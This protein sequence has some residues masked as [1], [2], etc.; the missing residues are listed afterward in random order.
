M[1]S[2]MMRNGW[3]SAVRL[4]LT[5]AMGLSGHI[6]GIAK[7]WLAKVHN[8]TL[9]QWA[10]C[11]VYVCALAPSWAA[12]EGETDTLT[13]SPQI[14]PMVMPVT[15][16]VVSEEDENEVGSGKI[17]AL[18]GPT[19]NPY[20]SARS[21]SVPLGVIYSANPDLREL[22]PEDFVSFQTP[23]GDQHT[24]RVTRA[25]ATRFGN[26]EIT[27]ENDGASLFIVA[28][29]TGDFIADVETGSQT[30]RAFISDGQTVVYSTDNPELGK[31]TIV[32]D[33][34]FHDLDD[35]NRQFTFEAQVA[36]PPPSSSSSNTVIALG[37]LV[38]NALAADQSVVADIEYYVANLNSAYQDA[39]ASIRF[40][41]SQIATY[42]PGQ[43]VSAGSLGPILNHITCGTIDCAPTSGVNKLVDDW[44]TANKLDMV[45]QLLKYAAVTQPDEE[46]NYSINWGIAQLPFS[47][48]DLT[49]PAILK[50]YTYSVNGLYNPRINIKAGAYLLAHEIGHNFGLWH[51]RETLVSQIPDYDSWAEL[52]PLLE[53]VMRYPYGIGYRFGESSGTTMSY[54][55]NNVNLLSTPN[56]TSNGGI[57]IGRPIGDSNQSFSAQAVENIMA[58]YKA[59]FSNTPPAPTNIEVNG[60][61]GKIVVSFSP[62]LSGG[63][64][65]T[66]YTATCTDGQNNFQGTGASSPITV[67]DVL[68][69]IPYTC[70]VIATNPDG[71]SPPS[72]S[73]S[74]VTLEEAIGGLPI[75]LLYEATK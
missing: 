60:D 15:A 65:I 35:V 69:D 48:V 45:A 1:D 9:R 67:D 18:G 26:I 46:G 72:E 8:V 51:D 58:Y 43:D 24:F 41:V 74:P 52:Q 25:K 27:G 21:G 32:N 23:T 11:F 75:W 40:E 28:T 7:F 64:A 38:D 20:R 56:V 6:V 68:N 39:G 12:S 19:D 13:D 3:I 37:L 63:L 53:P 57:S 14:I 17:V 66:G 36:P 33:T 4:A 44:R 61:D 50:Q 73:S 31:A 42:E 34:P 10:V 5:V 54:A 47:D 16:Q 2:T 59:V 29:K 22:L 30:Y 70:S 71:Q 55:D 62:A 49:D